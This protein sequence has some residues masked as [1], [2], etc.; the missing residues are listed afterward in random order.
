MQKLYYKVH[1]DSLSYSKNIADFFRDTVYKCM[2]Q[3]TE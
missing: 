1:F 3:L 2:V